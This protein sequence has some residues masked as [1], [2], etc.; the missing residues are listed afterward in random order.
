MDYTY[1]NDEVTLNTPWNIY[2][3]TSFITEQGDK[4][5]TRFDFS[6]GLPTNGSWFKISNSLLNQTFTLKT[7]PLPNG[8]EIKLT[9]PFSGV[10]LKNEIVKTL[11]SNYY[12]SKYYDVGSDMSIKAKSIGSKFN[13]QLEGSFISFDSDYSHVNGVDNEVKNNLKHWIRVVFDDD[14]SFE[15]LTI[16]ISK[17]ILKAYFE[18]DLRPVLA[19]KIYR[20]DDDDLLDIEH[21]GFQME[22]TDLI[23]QISIYSAESIGV[24]SE[25]LEID[26]LGDYTYM[27]VHLSE[28]NKH[29]T[30]HNDSFEDLIENLGYK[31]SLNDSP[32]QVYLNNIES[33]SFRMSHSQTQQ[34]KLMFKFTNEH[35]DIEVIDSNHQVYN[36]GFMTIYFHWLYMMGQ[37]SLERTDKIFVEIFT[38]K[39]NGDRWSK[40]Y[41]FILNTI[42]LKGVETLFVK[43]EFKLWETIPLVEHTKAIKVKHANNDRVKDGYLSDIIESE[44]SFTSHVLYQEKKTMEWIKDVLSISDSFMVR[45]EKINFELVR[46]KTLNI[47]NVMNEF[48]DIPL[49]YELVKHE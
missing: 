42:E 46:F 37:H 27:R 19:R 30:R 29:L 9:S 24:P 16:P 11:R 15:F 45:S 32:K 34:F 35:G 8:R 41:H 28:N 26:P 33:I 3:R 43:N 44:Y 40:S 10:S 1:L 5:D 13:F 6:G 48:D 38:V 12:I 21:D 22:E 18:T 2:A 7:N 14:T 20:Y 47:K 49:T 31:L 4:L 39:M 36:P 23:K 25:I 17:S